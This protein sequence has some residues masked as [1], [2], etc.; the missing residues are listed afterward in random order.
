M[1]IEEM[2]QQ[3]LEELAGR[4]ENTSV[5]MQMAF[6]ARLR[7]IAVEQL[8]TENK[9]ASEKLLNEAKRVS[10][11]NTS[12]Y[13][14]EYLTK[15]TEPGEFSS[16]L[17]LQ[18]LSEAFDVTVSYVQ[19]NKPNDITVFRPEKLDSPSITLYFTPKTS[20][21]S[22][23]PHWHAKENYNSTYGDGNCLYHAFAQ[24][25]YD[26][27]KAE[28]REKLAL[29]RSPVVSRPLSPVTNTP[30]TSMKTFSQPIKDEIIAH[31][32]MLFETSRAASKKT[33]PTSTP[34]S[35]DSHNDADDLAYQEHLKTLFPKQKK[36]IQ[37]DY[38]YALGLA[39][40]ELNKA[41]FFKKKSSPISS[42][43]SS[44]KTTPRK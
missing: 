28:Q 26:V 43:P 31:Q 12:T 4:E 35:D 34:K 33:S 7:A 15:Q 42:Q 6:A 40:E 39:K 22:P 30:T 44:T 37:D 20:P 11:K 32:R 14:N 5:A 24:A 25:M 9:K 16:E 19:T 17:E 2:K 23:P 41:R 8:K 1:T 36:Q 3:I 10:A 18:A 27:V 13:I 21:D 38:E 29:A